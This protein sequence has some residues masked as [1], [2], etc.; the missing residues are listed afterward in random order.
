M[1]QTEA[2]RSKTSFRRSA[3]ASSV[4]RS[5][6]Y[7]ENGA[8]FRF[9]QTVLSVSCVN[10]TSGILTSTDGTTQTIS[11]PMSQIDSSGT[12]L[13]IFCLH[14]ASLA[15]AGQGLPT[16]EHTECTNTYDV[17]RNIGDEG[18]HSEWVAVSPG[19]NKGLPNSMCEA[20]Y[21][22]GMA[23]YEF[24]CLT[25]LLQFP[26]AYFS[27][28]R[29]SPAADS[30][31]LKFWSLPIALLVTCG[32]LVSRVNWQVECYDKLPDRLNQVLIESN[33]ADLAEAS[34]KQNAWSLVPYFVAVLALL[35]FVVSMITPVPE[36]FQSRCIDP[37]PESEIR[38]NSLGLGS[39]TDSLL[40]DDDHGELPT[41]KSESTGG[42]GC[43]IFNL[44][45]DAPVV[46]APTVEMHPSSS[47]GCC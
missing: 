39:E 45:G 14:R 18:F 19:C 11:M 4:A 36:L 22:A 33:L 9:A 21:T 42:R 27:I 41:V 5:L 43:E 38:E 47:R 34:T 44:C 40:V 35:G 32:A 29:T 8:E 31:Y 1:L 17:C 24:L 23:T 10:L 37:D 28:M 15:D 16:G 2:T 26:L 46:A 12:Q 6:V 3:A 20:C 13:A 30:R 25:A 7:S